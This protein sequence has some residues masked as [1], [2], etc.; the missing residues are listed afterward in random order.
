M[1]AWIWVKGRVQKLNVKT[2]NLGRVCV[3]ERTKR[4][5]CDVVEQIFWTRRVQVRT[6]W[7]KCDKCLADGQSTRN[8]DKQ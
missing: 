3:I 4:R 8:I 7:L 2:T 6:W 1:P 5:H